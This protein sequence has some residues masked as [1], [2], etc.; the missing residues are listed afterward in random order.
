MMQKHALFL[1]HTSALHIPKAVELKYRNP[2]RSQ[3]L[4]PDFSCEKTEVKGNIYNY[5]ILQVK[6]RL[7]H[8]KNNNPPVLGTKIM[9]K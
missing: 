3:T 7:E 9:L 8:A 1:L 2:D 4:F 6:K 5:I